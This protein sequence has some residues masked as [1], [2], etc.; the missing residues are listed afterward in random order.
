MQ[1]FSDGKTTKKQNSSGD[2]AEGVK[3]DLAEPSINRNL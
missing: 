2:P 1:L 3:N